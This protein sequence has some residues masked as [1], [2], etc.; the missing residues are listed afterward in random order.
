VSDAT[1]PDVLVV[2]LGNPLRGDDG[3]GLE[4]VRHLRDLDG[5]HGIEVRE[6][7][8]DTTALLD[9]WLACDA[10]MLVDTMPSG[11]RPGTIRRLD[12]R[13]DTLPEPRHGPSS[14]HTAGLAQTI[15]LGRA[16]G[17]Q[18]RRLIVYAIEGLSFDPGSGLSD[19]VR[20]AISG[21][22]Q[23]VL[24]EATALQEGEETG[25]GNMRR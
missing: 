16:L 13:R 11:A 9:V 4:V 22:T 3:A 7:D 23:M 2:G 24:D 21:L 6:L 1:R 10:V 18:P 8:G 5:A 19:E 15:E 25:A 20:A 14:T 12:A 17:R